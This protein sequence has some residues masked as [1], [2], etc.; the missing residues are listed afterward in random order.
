[1]A[2]ASEKAHST[3]EEPI[4]K[5]KKKKRVTEMKEDLHNAVSHQ[6]KHKSKKKKEK[7]EC[8]EVQAGGLQMKEKDFS[9][10][11]VVLE[12]YDLQSTKKKDKSK[13]FK[14][15]KQKNISSELVTEDHEEDQGISSNMITIISERV[16]HQFK[17][18][19]KKKDSAVKKM[20]AECD[21]VQ[22]GGLPLKN[23]VKVEDFSGKSVVAE[24]YDPELN[25][26]KSLKKK[27]KPNR[28]KK[29]KQRKISSKLATKDHEDDEGISTNKMS[30]V[31]SEREGA[32]SVANGHGPVQK[33]KSK[34]DKE[35]K[36]KK[37][38][39]KKLCREK[40][41][42]RTSLKEISERMTV[43]E[44]QDSEIMWD[45]KKS[46]KAARSGDGMATNDSVLGTNNQM[47][48]GKERRHM[49]RKRNVTDVMDETNSLKTKKKRKEVVEEEAETEGLLENIK[50][51]G[52]KIHRKKPHLLQEA[53]QELQALEGY[54]IWAVEYSFI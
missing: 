1:M 31:I 2:I 10:N 25:D 28:L 50:K 33:K 54:K 3:A 45:K 37:K 14:K 42:K 51:T 19:S 47:D 9:G 32:R 21:E 36:K 34:K 53:W 38:K 52:R 41:G 26:L 48:D 35:T 6:F 5:K 11:S 23:K 29:K 15:K 8:D 49:K 17:H 22:A 39:K 13:H 24:Y 16:P 7:P 43:D 40:E 27:D 4:Q 18:K 30:K 46:K 12:Y 44:A 20:K